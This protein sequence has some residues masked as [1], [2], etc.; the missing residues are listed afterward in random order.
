[1]ICYKNVS[2]H[3]LRD[4]DTIRTVPIRY[5]PN[6]PIVT[7]GCEFANGFPAC[8]DCITHLSHYTPDELIALRENEV[9]SLRSL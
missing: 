4:H 5:I 7:D 9:I 2:V 1:M 3:C 6:G 8:L